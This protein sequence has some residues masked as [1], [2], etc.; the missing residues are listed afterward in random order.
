MKVG[1]CGTGR[2]GAAIAQRLIAV[3][4]EVGVWN[5]DTTKTEPLVGAGAKAFASPAALVEGCDAVVVML[6]NDAATEA[7][8]RGTN[9]LL[10]AK[11]AGKLV[12]DMSTI[13]PDTM[14]S[15]GDAVTKLGAGFVE[16]PVGGSTGPAKEGKLFGFVGGTEPDGPPAKRGLEQLARRWNHARLP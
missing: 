16:C 15:V 14:T 7:V 10:T 6:L 5:R 3:G 13:R 4:H 8:Y 9:G 12:I 2:M 1:V 11:L